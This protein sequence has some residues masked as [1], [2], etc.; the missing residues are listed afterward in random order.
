ML[1]GQ[2]PERL[3]GPSPQFSSS[4]ISMSLKRTSMGGPT[5]TCKAMTPSSS[6]FSSVRSM[7]RVPLKSIVTRLPFAVITKSFQSSFLTSSL[8]LSSG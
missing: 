2:G 6:N 8:A 4:V 1:P 3:W 5:W 7:M